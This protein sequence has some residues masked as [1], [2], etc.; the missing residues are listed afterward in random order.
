[1]TF[2]TD[3][4]RIEPMDVYH[5]TKGVIS[6]HRLATFRRCPL[7]YHQKETGIIG[8]VDSTAYLLGRGAHTLIVEGHEIF[9]RQYA[10]GGPV[11]PNTGKVYGAGTKAYKEWADV[12]GKPALTD[13]QYALLINM[14]EGVQ[15]NEDAVTLLAAGVAEGVT[16]HV[17]GGLMAQARLDLLNP[18]YGI[19]DL[20]TCDDLTWFE[21]DARRFEY[22]H[23]MAFYRAMVWLA[24]DWPAPVHLIA[25]EKKPPFRCGVWRIG[26]DALGL[27]QKENEAAIG[28]LKEC[29]KQNIWP[30]GYEAVRVMDSI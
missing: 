16:R 30:T 7:Q 6:S 18:Y 25:V 1:M 14:R 9:E 29:I 28:R 11:N 10:V 17:Y 27:A 21:Q 2:R 26:T 19:V 20:K 4:L 24:I 22:I 3:F 12:I 23:Q 5:A 8:D 13:D 15:R